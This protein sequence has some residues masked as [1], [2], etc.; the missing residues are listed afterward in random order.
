MAIVAEKNF[1]KR[2][3]T[4]NVEN[5]ISYKDFAANSIKK[6]IH[7]KNLSSQ[8]ALGKTRSDLVSFNSMTASVADPY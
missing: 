1:L 2:Q 3:G 6:P 7:A 4:V 5:R 8:I